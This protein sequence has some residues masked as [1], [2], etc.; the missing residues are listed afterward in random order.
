MKKIKNVQNKDKGFTYL[1]LIIGI[2]ILLIGLGFFYKLFASSRTS[3]YIA[4]EQMAMATVAQNV[5][6]VYI[7]TG[8]KD[9]AIQQGVGQGYSQITL[10]NP[11]PV[12]GIQTVT[13]TVN[14]RITDTSNPKYVEPF[15]LVFETPVVNVP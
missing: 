5:A 14:S 9:T 3:M 2:T 1:S 10:E 15:V 12:N 8:E 4:K 11:D 7:A 6:Q 13:I